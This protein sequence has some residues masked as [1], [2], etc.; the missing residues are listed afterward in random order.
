MIATVSRVLR[1]ASL[2][3]LL[4]LEPAQPVRG[5][6]RQHLGELIHLDIK[7][8]VR[9]NRVGQRISGD[10][11]S[12]SNSRSVMRE[13]VHVCI[14]DASRMMTDNASCYKAFAF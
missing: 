4:H 14:D 2:S 5:S 12:Q 11:K 1:K 9:F 10:R 8:M 7:M 6:L 3:R 13:Y